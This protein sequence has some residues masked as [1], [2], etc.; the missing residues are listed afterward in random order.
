MV[1]PSYRVLEL[2]SVGV[3]VTTMEGLLEIASE[4]DGFHVLSSI[5]VSVAVGIKVKLDSKGGELSEDDGLG[6]SAI[7]DV[8]KYEEG[9]NGPCVGELV[10]SYETEESIVQ[11]ATSSRSSDGPIV[12]GSE[13]AGTSL[14]PCSGWR[15]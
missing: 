14:E 4:T 3:E 13:E 9:A 1:A 12:R 2:A 5:F 8:C 10:A 6:G 11:S 7:V 15:W